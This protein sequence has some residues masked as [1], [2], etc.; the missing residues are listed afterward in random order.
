MCEQSNLHPMESDVITLIKFSVPLEFPQQGIVA[1]RSVNFKHLCISESE[2][3]RSTLYSLQNSQDYVTNATVKWKSAQNVCSA[4]F[5][6]DGAFVLLVLDSDVLQVLR[7]SDDEVTS[8]WETSVG[9]LE[10]LL[11]GNET[12]T[13]AMGAGPPPEPVGFTSSRVT[14]SVRG[15]W[16]AR[17]HWSGAAGPRLEA[18]A[19]VPHCT[20]FAASKDAVFCLT[21]GGN[22]LAFSAERLRP[23]GSVNLFSL[24]PA[25]GAEP[26]GCFRQLA[27]SG[28]GRTLA[29]ADSEG[30][31]LVGDVAGAFC[32]PDNSSASA[33]DWDCGL[34]I[35]SGSSSASVASD[36]SAASR[37]SAARP[38]GSQLKRPGK[39]QRSRPSYLPAWNA[40]LASLQKWRRRGGKSRAGGR[41][42]V[43]DRAQPGTSVLGLRVGAAE[44]AAWFSGPAGGVHRA[45]EAGTG[46]LLAGCPVPAGCALVRGGPGAADAFLSPDRLWL[47]L[48]GVSREALLAKLLHCTEADAAGRLLQGQ[49]WGDLAV[50]VAALE[51]GLRHRHMHVARFAVALH[52][53]AFKSA[54][55]REGS[56]LAGEE[57]EEE[58]AVLARLDE[59]F[60]AIGRHVPA[61]ERTTAFSEQL[62]LLALGHANTVLE[63]AR[64]GGPSRLGAAVARA[65]MA[66]V[67][68]LRGHLHGR[69]AVT[70]ELPPAGEGECDWGAWPGAGDADV[71]RAAVSGSDVPRL[72]AFL[73][74]RRGLAPR[75]ARELT[76]R[77]VD[78]WVLELLAEERV[79]EA[80]ER[81]ASLC[82]DPDEELR[83]IC[84][85]SR[86][87]PLRD[88]LAGH[89]L[90]RRL[91]SE[92][93]V[94]A[95]GFLRRLEA[96]LLRHD[97]APS[98][99]SPPAGAHPGSLAIRTV[100]RQSEDW[101]RDVLTV[102]FFNTLDDSLLDSVD[103]ERAWACLLRHNCVPLLLGWAAAW[104]GQPGPPGPALAA[105]L[106]RWPLTGEMVDA[107]GSGLCTAAT[108]DA[109]LDHLARQG[110][111]TDAER[112]SVCS[113]L[114]RLARC[115]RL[116]DVRAVLASPHSSLGLGELEARLAQFCAERRLHHVVSSC[117][118]EGGAGRA[119][120]GAGQAWWSLWRES[121]RGAG[122]GLVEAATSY[123]G[124]EPGPLVAV[125]G[126]LYAGLPL[127]QVPGARD[128]P[129]LDAILAPPSG[130]DPPGRD[131][132]LYRLLRSFCPFD[133]SRLFT[134][135]AVHT[136]SN[137][138]DEPPHFSDPGLVS[139]HGYKD[140][141]SFLHYLK[142]GRPS[143][144]AS[145]FVAE[146]LKT[147]G[148]L[149]KKAVAACCGLAHGLALQHLHERHVGAACTAFS[150]MLGRCSQPARVHLAAAGA[151]L[152]H[153]DRAGCGDA[154]AHRQQ[155]GVVLRGVVQSNAAVCAEFLRLLETALQEGADDN[156]DAGVAAALLRWQPALQ[157]A[158]LHRLRPPQLFLERCAA[159][160]RWLPFVLFAH[161][162]NYPAA[163]V[164]ELTRLFSS[165][166][167]REHLGLALR[168]GD[169][170]RPRE[171]PPGRPRL[172]RPDSHRAY[173]GRIG[174]HRAA[175][176]SGADSS[177]QLSSSS[178]ED[179]GA[180][181]AEEGKPG[182]LAEPAEGGD[183][184]LTLQR[185]HGA[186]D[187]CGAL[188]T[189]ACDARNP[190][191]AVLACCYQP[192]ALAACLCT[193]VGVSIGRGQRP[194][195]W[196]PDAAARLA[197][198]AVCAGHVG[199]LARGWDLF[200]PDSPLCPFLTFLRDCA[201]LR[202]FDEAVIGL[203]LFKAACMNLR[204]SAPVATGEEGEAE[205]A[206]VHDSAWI[207]G[208][209]VRL[210]NAALDSCFP[211]AAHQRLFLH[212]LCRASFTEHLPVEAPDYNHLWRVADC[213]AGSGVRVSWTR[214]LA[215]PSEELQA[216][217]DGLLA[218]GR[219]SHAL[220]LAEVARL[221][222]HRVL[223]VQWLSRLDGLLEAGEQFSGPNDTFLADCEEE[224]RRFDVDPRAAA[225][226]FRLCAGK[227]GSP[228]ERYCL[229]VHALAW[230]RRGAC[231][232]ACCAE[233]DQLELDLWMC[234]LAGDDTSL[235]VSESRAVLRSSSGQ[236]LEA[237]LAVQGRLAGEREA[238]RLEL[239]TG[240][241]LERGDVATVVRLEAM[242]QHS[243]QE[244]GLLLTS[245]RLAEGATSP[246]E[247]SPELRLLLAERTGGYHH[248][249]L[250]LSSVSSRSEGSSQP[251]AAPGGE[252]G[253]DADPG[254]T[255]EQLDTAAVLERLAGLMTHAAALG[256]RVATCYRV[257]AALHMPFKSVLAMEEPLGLLRTDCFGERHDALTVASA[258]IRAEGAGAEEVA[259]LLCQQ[260][261]EAVRRA[262]S[263]GEAVPCMVWGCDLD[264]S[265][266]LL[267]EL[268]PDA[269]PLGHRLLSAA[270]QVPG[271]SSDAL[272]QVVE[273]VVHA[274]DCFSAACSMEGI[275][276]VLR[277]ARIISRSLLRREEWGLMVR[278]LTGVRRFTE[279]S[280]IFQMLKKND[281][282]E[283]LLGKGMDKVPGLK[284][285][286]LDFLERHHGEDRD[287]A[288]LVALHF[289][290]HGRAGEQS[291]RDGEGRLAALP[292]PP[293]HCAETRQ[294][295]AA[296]ALD[297]S[298]AARHLLQAEKLNAA[299][300]AAHR[301]ELVALQLSLLGGV[302]PG[303][304]ATGVLGLAPD[305]V[306][307]LVTHTLS[308]PQARIVA[309][310]YGHPV[311]W[312]AALFQQFVLHG[313][314]DY[315]QD[316]S[317]AVRLG[318]A[319]VDDV[320]RRFQREAAVPGDA[321]ARMKRLVA[322]VADV[323]VR[324]RLASQL[325]FRDVVESLLASSSLDYLKDTV[326]RSGYHR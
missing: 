248:R 41:L 93:E 179:P 165:P 160:D 111:F 132:D 231:G 271:S 303:Q 42:S 170:R 153:L 110:V 83:E 141:L 175:E 254:L 210:A 313:R 61:D 166:G 68:R 45:Y 102:L 214:L 114:T 225:D 56:G 80:R 143:F 174:I 133:A 134:W 54:L 208:T 314:T 275:V 85:T 161:V 198:E 34:S 247:L 139:K 186:A 24:W 140:T 78:S 195:A 309:R 215:R 310:A 323:E 150:E 298:Q 149:N 64:D 77:E 300:G 203:K 184:F 124:G 118:R 265:C 194:G 181:G 113:V 40:Y 119:V 228:K 280:Y 251:G 326:W 277:R 302:P 234:W 33:A 126:A 319:L 244:L 246:Y 109:V 95:W 307:R 272:R 117:L 226:F 239:L 146:Q 269:A 192:S 154:L 112:R 49:E 274:H 288:R 316:L 107:V 27:V 159:R 189:A 7:L 317:H 59:L 75:A 98:S 11:R 121:L 245:L 197:E 23:L 212:T 30:R 193:W 60:R 17:F 168:L 131:V 108:R 233:E 87:S 324:Y 279:M 122:P 249:T 97:T 94:T 270:A 62:A 38:D 55:K 304:A 325:G 218:A 127:E 100:V 21:A 13:P 282:F 199:T 36:R 227:V 185:C 267:L 172:R 202:D 142:Q 264:G 259:D 130:R 29:V 312:G 289:Q 216:C 104:L 294:A 37:A 120:Q 76:R 26:P 28:D 291:L 169:R 177:P 147:H 69:A 157:F 266:H 204:N 5:S 57:K 74:A 178:G 70:R 25:G 52:A 82:R 260:I 103:G 188:L 48:G 47:P 79:D 66:H 2:S 14:L 230:L 237:R 89:L 232:Q 213:L 90:S 135:Q 6:E 220:R 31:V 308:F 32:P 53:Q 223:T 8:V 84:L 39:K 63:L 176:R 96:V 191:Y 145:M 286:A 19:E 306:S 281:R 263:Q 99:S 138:V 242:F 238:R 290:L 16:L 43:L 253:A 256:R 236:L 205:G 235:G 12:G 261:V 88:Y 182:C 123:L 229:L 255:Q 51:E 148:K 296:A 301:A 163:Q 20:C 262:A 252:G 72:M 136:P 187:P 1:T 125:A 200:L 50:P 293:R 299:M 73:V 273:L 180:G 278:L 221:P 44:L 222:C 209:A 128:V 201:V 320:A 71:V 18:S 171:T 240:L 292:A 92:A 287:T 156:D 243:C 137:G 285:A 217:L 4:T 250:R 183:M 258:L 67:V 224:F 9:H 297:F 35:A 295:L 322:G 151:V 311:D 65:V 10:Q 105:A 284:T 190:V 3:H 321:V 206:F 46:Q 167:L 257:A 144:A 219:F 162:F 106:R 101:R 283:F 129:L 158:S 155:L 173:Y 305:Q 268:C 315:L 211:S 196:T 22:V 91:L 276:G 116:R 86:N 81:L 318:P 15:R 241:L 164:L 58:A 152:R 207:A 115:G